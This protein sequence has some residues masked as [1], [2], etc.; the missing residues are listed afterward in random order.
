MGRIFIE[1]KSRPEEESV[2]EVAPAAPMMAVSSVEIVEPE[3]IEKV[4]EVVRTEYIEV[5]VELIK[6]VVKVEYVNVPYEVEKIVERIVEKP[7]EV[8]KEVEKV[9]RIEDMAKIQTLKSELANAK[10]QSRIYA[11]GM[12]IMIIL[13]MIMGA[14][15]V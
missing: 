4:V 11:F 9:I 6:E 1:T 3:V 8:I 14:G 13:T 10:R 5:P 7:V 15:Y 12:A 2:I